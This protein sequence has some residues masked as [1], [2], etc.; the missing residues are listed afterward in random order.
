MG[1]I[2]V[3]RKIGD[4]KILIEL[5]NDG[6]VFALFSD[7]RTEDLPVE[8]L[9]QVPDSFPAFLAKMRAYLDA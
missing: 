8:E 4:R 7:R 1:G 3:T 5:Y 9:E 2:A 6:R